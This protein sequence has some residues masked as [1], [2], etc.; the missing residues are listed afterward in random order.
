MNMTIVSTSVALSDWVAF[1]TI[2]T[3]GWPVAEAVTSSTL[4]MQKTS[5]T[6]LSSAAGNG[7]GMGLKTHKW[8]R[9]PAR[10]SSKPWQ[11]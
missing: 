5:V 6:K 10:N 7:T 9:T 1:K 2:C 4:P 11:S 3:Y 8:S